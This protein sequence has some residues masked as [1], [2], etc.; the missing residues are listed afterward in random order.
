V[1]Q[2]RRGFKAQDKKEKAFRPY[3]TGPGTFVGRVHSPCLPR[4]LVPHS[5]FV[6]LTKAEALCEGRA[7]FENQKSSNHISQRDRL[8]MGAPDSWR[9]WEVKNAACD[10]CD[11]LQDWVRVSPCSFVVRNFVPLVS[12][13]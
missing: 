12:F 8:L 4:R 10:G 7:R 9:T 11:T 6:V 2:L 1:P 5:G 3:F 13:L